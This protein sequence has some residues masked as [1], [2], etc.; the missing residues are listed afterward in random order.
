MISKTLES[1]FDYKCVLRRVLESSIGFEW[2]RER[3]SVLVYLPGAR[4]T[5][6][7]MINACVLKTYPNTATWRAK[8]YADRFLF[9]CLIF[10]AFSRITFPYS[11][12]EDSLAYGFTFS[13]C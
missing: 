1:G 13:C 6:S 9:V 2:C 7:S 5:Q 4:Q 8:A 10:V 11:S 12:M 3:R